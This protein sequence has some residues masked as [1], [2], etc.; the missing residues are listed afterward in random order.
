[1]AALLPAKPAS[2]SPPVSP[3]LS[4]LARNLEQIEAALDCGI[5]EIHADFEDIRRGKDAVALVRSREDAGAAIF[6]A[7]PRIQKSG[8]AGYFKLIERAGP[9]GVLLRNLGALGHFRDH[10]GLRRHG[11]FSLNVANPITA[12]LL[13][14]SARLDRLTISYDLNINQ[15]LDLLAAA[16][17]AW[18][19]LTLHQHMPMFHMEHC[20]FCAF[21]S[22]G[23]D[24]TNCGRPCE[25]HQVVM[26]DR[27]GMKHVLHADVGCRNTLF[28]GQA[29]T[30][31][32]FLPALLKAGLPHYRLELLTEDRDRAVGVIRMYQDLLDGRA[33]PATAWRTLKATAQL[34]VTEG[35]LAV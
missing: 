26:R 30:G 13:R 7:T 19:E 22:N 21:L 9:D 4:V 12:S 8:E 1:M 18:F 23:T 31:A 29:Q 10:E 15:V 3:V 32:Q 35:T 16:P 25:K 33:N 24:F 14:E 6:L 2:S 11:D 28:R 17:P 27:V 20:V 5:T 34:G